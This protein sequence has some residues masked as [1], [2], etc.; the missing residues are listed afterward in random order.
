VLA[1]GL[2][3][4]PSRNEA[5]FWSAYRR[6]RVTMVADPRSFDGPADFARNDVLTQLPALRPVPVYVGCGDSDPFEPMAQ[7][8]RSRLRRLTGRPAAG[9]IEAGCH[10]STFWARTLP[11]G[12]SFVSTYLR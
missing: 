11:D 2:G 1:T 5:Q 8:L 4:P 7:L 6:Q 12:L 3:P 9:A 10:D